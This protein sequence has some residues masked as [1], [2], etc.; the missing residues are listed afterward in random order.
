MAAVDRAGN[1][2]GYA[3]AATPTPL[4]LADQA[5]GL[6]TKFAFYQNYPNPF[7]MTTRLQFDVPSEADIT[8]VI[9]DLLGRAIRHLEAG[10]LQPGTHFLSWDGRSASGRDLASG[11][12]IA[13]FSVP[14]YTRSVKLVLLK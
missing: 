5:T 4:A 9:Y 13:R 8:I 10:R 12:Y 2:S 1:I 6:P 7:N 3:E 11:I 14:A